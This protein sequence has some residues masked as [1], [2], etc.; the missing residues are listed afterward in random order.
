M[1]R[2]TLLIVSI[3]VLALVGA[4]AGARSILDLPTEVPGSGL[5]EVLPK[6]QERQLEVQRQHILHYCTEERSPRGRRRYVRA[7][8]ELIAVAKAKP[9]ALYREGAAF[10][11]S[12]FA[13]QMKRFLTAEANFI[14]QVCSEAGGGR[15]W[16]NGV[17]RLRDAARLLSR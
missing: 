17:E 13:P 16:A 7:I 9:N 5:A 12:H 8:D 11:H 2:R 4:A 3:V 1:S 15:Q 6:T 10:S 14:S